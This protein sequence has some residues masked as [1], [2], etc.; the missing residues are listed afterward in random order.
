M[1]IISQIGGFF[2]EIN[3]VFCGKLFSDNDADIFDGGSS[4][5]IKHTPFGEGMCFGRYVYAVAFT[6][7]TR[8]WTSSIE[9]VVAFAISS[10]ERISIFISLIAIWYLS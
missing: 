7:A 3:N 6:I 10:T 9:R 1:N 4:M 2:N 5:I 8:A